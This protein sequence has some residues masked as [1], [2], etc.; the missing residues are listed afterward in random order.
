[1]A[2]LSEYTV[3]LGDCLWDIAE[4]VLGDPYDWTEIAELNGISKDNPII[5]PDQELKLP[6][7]TSTTTTTVN[8][9]NLVSIEYFGL[10]AGTDRTVFAAWKWD[11]KNTENYQVKWYYATGNGL[12]FI[13]TDSTVE[14][15]QSVYNA[16]QNAKKVKLIVKPKSKTYTTHGQKTATY[17]TADWSTKK[18]YNFSDNPPSKPAVPTVEI[19]GYKL[20]A[21]LSNLDVNGTHIQFQVVQDDKKVFSTGKSKIVTT[22]ASYSCTVNAGSDYKV[23]CRAVR[24]TFYSEWTEYSANVGTKPS[25]SSGITVCKANSETSVYLEWAAVS[26][27]KTYDV[28]YATKKEYFDGSNSTTS[29]TG[30]LYNH[31]LF[32]GLESGQEYL[33]RV[34]AVN[35]KGESAWSE[36]KSVTI[37]KTPSAPTTWSSTT[38]GATGEN[39]TLYWVHNAEDGSTQTYAEIEMYVGDVKETHTI[40][41]VNEADDNKTMHYTFATSSYSEGMKIEWR[42][43]TAGVTKT[44]GEWSIQRTIDIYAPP[45]LVIE[46]TDNTGAEL[47]E[48]TS[49]PFYI[50]GTTGPNTQSPVGYHVSIAANSAYET[51]DNLGNPKTVIAGEEV[52]SRYFDTD[53][54][55]LLELS[56]NHISLENNIDYTIT[57][58]VSMNS[59]LSA[60]A[61]DDFTVAWTTEQ[62]HPNAEIGINED[63]ISAYIHP[64]CRDIDGNPIP[65]MSLAIYRREFDGTFTELATGLDNDSNTFVTDPHPALDYARYRVVA[66]DN[67]TGTVSY[68]DVPGH[69]VDEHAVVIQWNEDWTNFEANTE[70]ELE[71]PTWSGSM[72]KLPYNIDVSDKRS[73]DTSL[74]NYIGRKH[75]VSY[76]GTHVGESQDWKVVIPKDDKETLYAIRRLSIW[77]GDV[78]VREPSGSGYWA[79]ISVSFSQTHND[80]TIPVSISVTR[81]EG[82]V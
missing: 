6:S 45:T 57:C 17:W 25:A 78:Y 44:Y 20:T 55:L 62:C 30:I 26:N 16:P 49:F 11:K 15:K 34:R 2:S 69:P 39:V 29:T 42:V 33:F 82:G 43:R 60:V 46:V 23:R 75:P 58:T 7:S 5:Y 35:D 24:D 70:D 36:I 3:K 8:L 63:D 10:Q 80:L 22:A 27:V 72:L 79:S 21:K 9:S 66:T 54:Q 48:L 47:T 1:M 52:Y 67:V 68:Y 76:Y 19:D 71:Q 12:W 64:Y 41:S 51:V 65:N 53:K 31:Y 77:M 74:I 32:T 56:A 50:Q 28:E 40:N 13:G 18:E 59:G 73:L 38:T 81:V 4:K 61:T 37:G 14:E